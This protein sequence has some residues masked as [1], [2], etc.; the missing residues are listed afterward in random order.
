[1]GLH[2]RGQVVD[3][4]L[5]RVDPLKVG[6]AIKAVLVGLLVGSVELL[7]VG[8]QPV[9]RSLVLGIVEAVGNRGNSCLSA[10]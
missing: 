2:Q 8:T 3:P 9:K 10:S 6:G 7:A 1:V 5:I 4:T